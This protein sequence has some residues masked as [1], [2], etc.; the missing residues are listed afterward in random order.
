MSEIQCPSCGEQFTVDEA[1][2][3]AIRQQ[4]HD[5]EFEKAV[6]KAVE[7][8]K[9]ANA[10]ELEVAI[11]DKDA[12]IQTLTA[13]IESQK[14]TQQIAVLEEVQKARNEER[15]NASE[16][17][18]KKT[19]QYNKELASKDKQLKENQEYID[20][21]NNMKVPST[22]NVIG[23][24]LE[25]FCEAKFN[26]IRHPAFEYDYFEKDT[27][28][29]RGSKG[30]YI[31]RAFEEDGTEI[32]SIMFEMKNESTVTKT[33]RKNKDFLKKLDEDRN[34]KDCEYAILVSTLES[35]DD[36]WGVMNV[37]HIHPRMYIVRPQFFITIIGVIR[38]EAR[39]RL[40]SKK[41]LELVRKNQIDAT[42]L[43]NNLTDFT[44]MFIH[45]CDES[46]QATQNTINIL[47]I[48]IANLSK[49]K[50]ELQ[51]KALIKRAE[52]KKRL[53]NLTV[54]KLAKDSPTLLE[55][56]NDNKQTQGVNQEQRRS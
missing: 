38:N 42:N 29:K 56:L 13:K 54:E 35:D 28:T 27:D 18:K 11:K 50:D 21:L 7:Q 43:K 5:K 37:S 51:S 47:E 45:L 30:D 48:T 14:Q 25:R 32:V 9:R 20:R 53:S 10:A 26:E 12:E 3:A 22:I 34:K 49:A 17:M 23:E 52:A 41:E 40:E 2:Y 24:S 6:G 44:S 55:Q 8:I 33:K 36:S 16:E 19:T 1:G 31:Y 15:E 4:V 39:K 46:D